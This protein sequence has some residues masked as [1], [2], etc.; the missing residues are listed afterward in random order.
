VCVRARARNAAEIERVG[1]ER[2]SSDSYC[3][4]VVCICRV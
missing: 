4:V 2:C 1:G 3:S